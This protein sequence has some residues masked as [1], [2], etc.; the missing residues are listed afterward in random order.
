[1]E[2]LASSTHVTGQVMYRALCLDS[3]S[4][5][6][7]ASDLESL[8]YS[9]MHIASDGYALLWRHKYTEDDL[10]NCKLATMLSSKRWGRALNHCTDQLTPLLQ[11]WHDIIFVPCHDNYAYRPGVATTGSFMAALQAAAQ[12]LSVSLS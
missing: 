12:Q 2:H 6:T 10:Y 3:S 7:V 1:M 5:H 8:L 9:L 11:A 4:V